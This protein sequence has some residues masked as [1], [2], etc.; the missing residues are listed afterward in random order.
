M[1][2]PVRIQG[3]GNFFIWDSDQETPNIQHME[4]EYDDGTILQFE[5]R[6]LGTNAEGGIRIG[7]LIFG[8]KGW[9]DIANEDVGTCQAH[10]SDIQIMPSGY[11][12]YAE[13]EGPVFANNDPE[14][15]DTVVQHFKNFIDCVR[16]RRWQDLH[17]DIQEGHLSTSLCHLGNIACRLKRSL[18][19]NPHAETFINDPEADSYLT[20]AYRSPYNLPE[21][22]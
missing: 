15:R 5:V 16:S 11:S 1:T 21:K 9:M 14:T 12:S 22:V 13:E 3:I 8:S 4:F 19:F 6:G 17:A 20:K 2:H 7:N 18:R 10:M